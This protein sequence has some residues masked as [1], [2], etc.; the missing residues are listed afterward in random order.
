MTPEE[1]R[2]RNS[3]HEAAHAVYAIKHGVFVKD[4][5]INK[6]RLLELYVSLN[7][8]GVTRT[9]RPDRPTIDVCLSL[10]GIAVT[11][12]NTNR[13]V[14]APVTQEELNEATPDAQNDL[15]RIRKL[16][17]DQGLSDL[18]MN[19]DCLICLPYSMSFARE[20]MPVIKAVAEVVRNQEIVTG[21]EV[22]DIIKRIENSD[23]PRSKDLG[24]L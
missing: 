23:G 19:E 6:D 5:S 22:A 20:F 21:D 11:I 17:R 9:A 14:G 12:E 24:P 1:K 7:C 10:M 2:I 16:Y 8:E 18:I 3:I 15:A 13:P 4:I